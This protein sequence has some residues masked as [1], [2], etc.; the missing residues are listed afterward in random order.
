ML[1]MFG[2]FVDWYMFEILF[3]L[4]FGIMQKE[5]MGNFIIWEGL[6]NGLDYQV[7]VQVYNCVF[8]LFSW[9][10]WFVFEIL[11]G[12]LFV[13]VVFMIQEF[14][15][16]GGQVQMCVSWMVFDKNGDV[17]CGYWLEVLWGGLVVWM[18][19]LGFEVMSQVIVVENFEMVYIYCIQV[20]NKVGWG[21]M[22]VF[23]VFC[24]GVVVFGVLIS[25]W[26]VDE[27]DCFLIIFFNEGLCNGVVFGEIMNQYWF[28][29]GDWRMVFGDKVFCGFENG[30]NYMVEV[31]VVVNVDGLMYFG[32]VF[33]LVIGN[34]YGKL[35]VFD[36]SV[37]LFQMDVCF[38]WNVNGLFN[39]CSIQVVQISVDGGGWQNVGMLG[40]VNVGMYSEYYSI[41]V[42]V[43]D[44]I[45]VWFDESFMCGV[46][47]Q[48]K[49]QLWWW[50]LQGMDFG[51]CNF[52]MCYY[53]N[54]NMVNVN[55]G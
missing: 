34:L 25:L 29:G 33:N 14:F 26:I 55:V 16:V 6:E 50:V 22:S 35:Y 48:V 17:I 41:K 52:D 27:G 53:L 47:V 54:L 8:D 44:N 40:L 9:S 28:N 1:L 21:E 24:C 18:L 38:N 37:E 45:G 2:F 51:N 43:M 42:W 3:V 31:C 36:V 30:V 15:L 20:N 11:V 49:L 4:F 5:V 32:V 46:M 7:C 13:F 10:G 39:G 19:M 23:F 12:L